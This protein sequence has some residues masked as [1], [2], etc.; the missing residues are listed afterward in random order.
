[1]KKARLEGKDKKIGVIGHIGLIKNP[2]LGAGGDRVRDGFLVRNRSLFIDLPA[3]NL[4]Y[5]TGTHT[6]AIYRQ[7]GTHGT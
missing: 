3:P 6:T 7:R 4:I 2:G 5:F 1:L